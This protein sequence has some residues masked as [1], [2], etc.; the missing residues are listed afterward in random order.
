MIRTASFHG[1]FDRRLAETHS[2][3]SAVIGGL[4]DVGA[5]LSQDR[6]K[7]IERARV[8][9]QMHSQAHQTSVL[10]EAALDDAREQGDVYI[11]AA[12]QN[13]NFLAHQMQFAVHK[14]REG[15]RTR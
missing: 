2:V 7:S 4:D 10:D 1:D 6:R 15:R 8:I 12:Y 5:M 14:R 9:R 3:V 13:G 11:S